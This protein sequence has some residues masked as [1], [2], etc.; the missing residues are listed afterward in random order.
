MRS[1]VYEIAGRPSVCP[2]LCLSVRPFHHSAAARRCG[3][4]AAVGRRAA[5]IDRQQPRA[6]VLCQPT[7]EAE[8]SLVFTSFTF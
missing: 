7:Q 8:R 6:V 5:D 1:G 4:F 3:R 2:S